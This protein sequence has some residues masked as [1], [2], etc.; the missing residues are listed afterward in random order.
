MGES[1]ASTLTS[2]HTAATFPG[3]VDVSKCPLPSPAMHRSTLG[4]DT[5]VSLLG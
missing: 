1:S 5:A 3:S 2:V 4:Q